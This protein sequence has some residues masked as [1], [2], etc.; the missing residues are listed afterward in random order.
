MGMKREWKEGLSHFTF[1]MGEPSA[2]TFYSH[3]RLSPAAKRW[4][5]ELG[6]DCRVFSNLFAS[7]VEVDGERFSSSETYFQQFKYGPGDRHFLC[8]LENMG[9]VASFG[10]RRLPIRLK[11]MNLIKHLKQEGLPIPLKP[12]GQEYELKDKANP[13]ILVTDWDNV[14]VRKKGQKPSFV[15]THIMNE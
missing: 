15:S 4:M 10:Q 14:K 7:P 3:S 9:D 5:K 1:L 12:D 8:R 2:F 6:V 13:V 11:H